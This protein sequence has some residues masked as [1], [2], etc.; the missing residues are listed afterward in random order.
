VVAAPIGFVSD[1]LEVIWD[2]DNEAAATAEG[3]GIDWR[4]VATPGTDPRFV[5]MVA[6]LVAERVSGA[7]RR[8][9]GDIPVWDVCAVNCC[10]I[11]GRTPR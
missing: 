8:K 1:H 3:L 5:A 4:R 10:T 2:L 9:L 7:S 6:E 11:P